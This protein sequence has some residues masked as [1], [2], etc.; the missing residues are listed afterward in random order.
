MSVSGSNILS[1]LL[2]GCWVA[3]TIKVRE[4]GEV[5]VKQSLLIVYIID[6]DVWKC[7]VIYD[8]GGADP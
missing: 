4:G 5:P 6:V 2:S 3:S 8:T 7:Y 1:I